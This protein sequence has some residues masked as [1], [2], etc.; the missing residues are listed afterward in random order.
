MIHPTSVHLSEHVQECV[1]ECIDCHGV[2]LQT[3][4]YCLRIGGRHAEATHIRMLEDCAEVCQTAANLMLRDS[5]LHES[6]CGV[7]ADVCERCAQDC[8]RF[9]D[10][11]I[12][13]GCAD[14]CRRC[15]D[16]CRRVASH[17]TKVIA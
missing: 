4:Q 3:I 5:D 17:I 11:S 13:K 16:A 10:D 2:C 9:A 12:M 15:A 8:D 6:I 14:A 1:N 7:C